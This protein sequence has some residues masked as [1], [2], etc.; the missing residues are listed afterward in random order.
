ML[1]V[2]T[3]KKCGFNNPDDAH[4]CN[5]CGTDFTK[6]V[7]MSFKGWD[8]DWSKFYRRWVCPRCNT[9]NLTENR[10]CSGCFKKP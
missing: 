8:W 6:S 7:F 3:C 10:T 5:K 1:Y 4:K 2:K 9:L